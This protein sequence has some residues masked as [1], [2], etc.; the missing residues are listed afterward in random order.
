LSIEQSRNSLVNDYS[1]YIMENVGEPSQILNR[2]SVKVKVKICS[3]CSYYTHLVENLRAGSDYS[4]VLSA[5]TIGGC[6]N[7]SELSVRMPESAPNLD[8]LYLKVVNITS[9]S[10][11]LK[12]TEPTEPNGIITAYKLYI[13]GEML[14]YVGLTINFT[15]E[16]LNPNTQYYIHVECCTRAGCS[17]T[18]NR[19]L[20]VLTEDSAPE[21]LIRLEAQTTDSSQIRVKWYWLKSNNSSS[22]ETLK[23]NGNLIYRVFVSGPF[24]IEF[25][26]HNEAVE[27]KRKNTSFTRLLTLNLLNTTAMNIMYAIIDRIL[28]YSTYELFVNASNSKGFLLSNQVKLRTLKAAPQFALPPQLMSARSRSMRLEWFDPILLNSDDTLVYNQV[29]YRVKRLWDANGTIS[30]PKWSEQHQSLFAI[31]TLATNY[32]LDSLTPYT[33]YSF[34]LTITNSYGH[35][36]SDWSEDYLTKEER[37]EL[38]DKPKV[39]TYSS[40]EAL[41]SWKPPLRANGIIKSYK[42]HVYKLNETTNQTILIET[43]NAKDTVEREILIN[44]LDAFQ[45]YL[46][47]IECCNYL[48]CTSSTLPTQFESATVVRTL[49][50]PPEQLQAPKVNVL[51]AYSTEINWHMPNKPN[52][53]INYFILERYDHQPPLVHTTDKITLVLRQQKRSIHP[54][55]TTRYR[56]EPTKFKFI[57]KNNLES[58]GN[59][60]YRLI[61]VNQAGSTRSQWTNASMLASSPYVVSAPQVP[62]VGIET[63]RFE[64][65]RPLTY[66]S[67]SKYILVLDGASPTRHSFE[68]YVNESETVATV[69]QLKPFTVYSLTL[70]ACV[71]E[72]ACTES[73]SKTFKTMGAVPAGLA[74]PRVRKLSARTAIVEWQEPIA[75]NGQYINYQLIRK[76][77]RQ[78]DERD[79]RNAP[80]HVQIETVY[81]G[82]NSYFIDLNLDNSSIVQYKVIYGNEFGNSL[83]EWSIEIVT[84]SEGNETSEA[85]GKEECHDDLENKNQKQNN[86]RILPISL[87]FKSFSRSPTG[88]YLHWNSYELDELVKYAMKSFEGDD[89]N[90]SEADRVIQLNV[91]KNATISIQVR[92]LFPNNTCSPIY[93]QR[94]TTH[95]KHSKFVNYL[96]PSFVYIF[97]L[98]IR[99]QLE[100]IMQTDNLNASIIEKNLILASESS[101]CSTISIDEAFSDSLSLLANHSSFKKNMLLV[102]YK[103]NEKL[104]QNYDS[105]RLELLVLANEIT[106]SSNSNSIKSNKSHTITE[107]SGSVEFGPLVSNVAYAI[108]LLA[109]FDRDRFKE[110]NYRRSVRFDQLDDIL[111]VDFNCIES[112]A[113]TYSISTKPPENLS[114]PILTVLDARSIRIEWNAPLRL[115]DVSQR[116]TYS[117][118]KRRLEA[119]NH[120]LENYECKNED[121]QVLQDG[122]LCCK[123]AKAGWLEKR[124]K[125]G[126]GDSCCAD[127]PYYAHASVQVCCVG[128]ELQPFYF[129]SDSNSAVIDAPNQMPSLYAT[130]KCDK[131]FHDLEYVLLGNLTNFSY[132]DN[133]LLASTTYEYKLCARNS[134]DESCSTAKTTT[135]PALPCQLA[136]FEYKIFSEYEVLLKWS[137]PIVANGPAISYRLYRNSVEIYSGGELSF[138][139]KVNKQNKP[140][141]RDNYKAI[142]YFIE[143]CNSVGCIK[144]PKTLLVYL[145]QKPPQGFDAPLVRVINSTV[146][147][148]WRRPTNPNGLLSKFV[149][150]VE[151]I[152]LELEI[153]FSTNSTLN[154]HT[155]S[156]GQSIPAYL[157]FSYESLVEDESP[158]Y[159]LRMTDLSAK[160]HHSFI[161]SCCND[162]GCTKA[163][164]MSFDIDKHSFKLTAY[165][166]L[167]IDFQKPLVYILNNS[168]VDVVWQRPKVTGDWTLSLSDISY[169]FYRNNLVVA[170]VENLADNYDSITYTDS[171]LIPNTFYSYRIEAHIQNSIK[172]TESASIRTPPLTFVNQ[173][174]QRASSN[175]FTF[176]SDYAF[177]HVLDTLLVEFRVVDSTRILMQYSYSN[178]T[179][180]FMCVFSGLSRVSLTNVRSSLLSKLFIQSS[181]GGV[182]TID[183]P[184]PSDN[185]K[186]FMLERKL[187]LVRLKLVCFNRFLSA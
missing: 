15:I 24:L 130:N 30:E 173:C 136:Q 178:L 167:L 168:A 172:S 32:R 121:Q 169:K 4:V 72:E 160:I 184:Y 48:G 1:L 150:E 76:T 89:E 7:S 92:T 128:G 164:S 46:F 141:N 84:P 80:N 142:K 138:A 140:T 95:S 49:A 131:P 144:G 9:K 28:P 25:A 83:S 51:S 81:I 38:I 109:C 75:K 16:N 159:H 171:Q 162:L 139:D 22:S 182:Q 112:N 104:L 102:S 60:S 180:M 78:R 34:R 18:K 122:Y 33:A 123:S 154:S 13:N 155:I 39:L 47:S 100:L 129:F 99:L 88:C 132:V 158:E 119:F 82:K 105:Y 54:K 134:Y 187:R 37:P 116:I 8:D 65:T 69:S 163:P 62:F 170:R 124:V 175:T 108:R 21:G 101:T 185:E 157:F 41:I 186:K 127:K 110:S 113:L 50:R 97:R 53:L 115:N 135:L 77:K 57:D 52:G 40:D 27:L 91:I 70:R 6:T 5:C 177:V 111:F 20:I 56:F 183:F 14:I 133:G 11:T 106:T 126:Y 174:N 73:L 87:A 35:T 153:Y 36:V 125:H 96:K 2:R 42:I 137:K 3:E 145:K 166:L 176:K 58:C 74:I 107:Q 43:V 147:L 149:V 98:A 31:K 165:Q 90:M 55:N 64:W 19:Q 17:S 179:N 120:R 45:I 61:A 10:I 66:C 79:T 93:E 67:I 118:Y 86:M 146:E 23:P 148:I 143:A 71:N 151:E 12:W 94:L 63:A 44:K 156:V 59:Y 152:D 114:K 117:L 161:V 85:N 26:N 181:S 68:V 29:H 103:L